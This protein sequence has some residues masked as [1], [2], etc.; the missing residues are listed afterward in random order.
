[1]TRPTQYQDAY[2]E[3]ARALA[4]GGATDREVAEFLEVSERTIHRWKIDHP[5]FGAALATGKEAA[6][7]RVEHSLYRKAIGYSYDS[8]K[9][10]HTDGRITRAPF[11]EHVP[12]SDTAAIFW[13][14]NRMPDQYREKTEVEINT[15]DDLAARIAAGRARVA[16]HEEELR[17][18]GR[19]PPPPPPAPTR[20]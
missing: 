4:F 10:F 15:K 6:D 7:R 1:M 12:P 18:E 14:K 9:I 17:R 3:T 5:E 2:A 19:S 11:V 20:E 16:A 8:E 13:L